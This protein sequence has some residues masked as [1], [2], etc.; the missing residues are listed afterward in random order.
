VVTGESIGQK[1]SQ[2]AANLRVVDDAVSLPVHRPLLTYDKQ[3][4]VD[5]AREIGTYETSTVDTGCVQMAP[6]KPSTRTS[7]ERV[8]DDEPAGL[9][10]SAERDARDADVSYLRRA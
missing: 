3:E 5:L 2:T 9:L 7:V 10:E 8:R 1:S 4:I 6:D